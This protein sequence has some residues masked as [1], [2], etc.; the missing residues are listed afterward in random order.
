M[1]EG[2]ALMLQQ[3]RNNEFKTSARYQRETCSVI[4]SPVVRNPFVDR[5]LRVRAASSEATPM[6]SSV[7]ARGAIDGS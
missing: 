6:R 3:I 5:R 2:P 7:L 4:C 1:V